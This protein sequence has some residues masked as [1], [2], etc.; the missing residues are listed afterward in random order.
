M[1]G[2]ISYI[3]ILRQMN[4]TRFVVAISTVLA[5][6]LFPCRAE[7]Q[8]AVSG[9]LPAY[10]SDS[11]RRAFDNQPYF[12]LYK[13]NYF[14]FGGPVDHRMTRTNTN[15]K[16][17][18]SVAQRLTRS[19]L[20]GGTYLYLFYTQ[21]CFWNVLEESFPMTDLNFNPGIGITKNIFSKGRYIGKVSL[22]AEHESNGRD[23]VESRSW[24]RLSL[25]GNIL[26][27]RSIMLHMK[28]WLPWVDGQNNTDLLDY[29]GIYQ[30]GINYLN[31]R[32]RFSG[33]VILTKRRGF[34]LNF[35]TTVELKF[36]VMRNQN[37]YLFLQFY[38]GFGEGMLD[39]KVYKSHLRLGFVIAPT[40]FSDY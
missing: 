20:P 21:K 13:D 37:Q 33:S 27:D 15:V 29:Y 23:S 6:V 24:N 5:V 36:K 17:Q 10:N 30:M 34:N 9:N 1:Y 3:N 40:F 35:N 11:L 4:L 2:C 39:Y 26:I 14:I 18:I 28:V 25:A 16:F 19:V 32:G 8:I 7:A 31:M 12:G 22:I 38:N